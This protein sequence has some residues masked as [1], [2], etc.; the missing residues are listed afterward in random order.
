MFFS[1]FVIWSRCRNAMTKFRRNICCKNWCFFQISLFGAG[2]EML[3]Q[4]SGDIFAVK[5]DVFSKFVIWSR[6][7][8]AMTKLWRHICCKNWCFFKFRYWEPASKFDNKMP[9][10]IF[11]VK[12]DVFSNFVIGSGGAPLVLPVG[13][14][15]GGGPGGHPPKQLYKWYPTTSLFTFFMYVN[16]YTYMYE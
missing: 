6:W 12:T 16:L 8:N 15:S 5:T 3:W 2:V 4:N 1:N 13:G 11:S 7:R 14:G 10:S 9:G